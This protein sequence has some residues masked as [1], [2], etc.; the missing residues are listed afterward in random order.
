MDLIY[1]LSLNGFNLFTFG[2]THAVP[3]FVFPSM[4]N[5]YTTYGF[6][7]NILFCHHVL[8]LSTYDDKIDSKIQNVI[9]N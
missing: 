3:A 7:I 6:I 4:Y 5:Y 2:N 8:Y 1:L 9:T